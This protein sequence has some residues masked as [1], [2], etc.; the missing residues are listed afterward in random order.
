MSILNQLQEGLEMIFLTGTRCKIRFIHVRFNC[1]K[2]QNGV[3][4]WLKKSAIRGDGGP[5]PN[6]KSHETFPF[7]FLEYF[8]NHFSIYM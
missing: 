2:R 1:K 7:S 4:K 5:L 8:P 3:K 6:G